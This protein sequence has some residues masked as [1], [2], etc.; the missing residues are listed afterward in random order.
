MPIG[1]TIRPDEGD[2]RRLRTALERMAS[3]GRSAH[4][5]LGRTGEFGRR[6]AHRLLRARP[7]DWGKHTL[8]LSLSIALIV[9]EDFVGWGS[10]LK[11]ARIQ[12]L[13]GRVVPKG[14]K[15]LA[16]PV[17]PILRAKGTWPRD[18]APDT[19]KFVSRAHITIGSHSW[20]GPALVR[21]NDVVRPPEVR[22]GKRVRR[23]DAGR[24][25][26]KDAGKAGEVMFALVKSVMIRGRPYLVFS[27]ETKQFMFKQ[28]DMEFDRISRIG[29]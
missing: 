10:N 26:R 7:K 28:F 4:R 20:D 2:L 16:I 11:Y 17:S 25:A 9:G 15:Y 1:L 3:V 23:D 19:M 18:I 27:E 8:R 14:H 24:F 22:G 13:G 21:K 5:L 6:E 29:R 12:Q